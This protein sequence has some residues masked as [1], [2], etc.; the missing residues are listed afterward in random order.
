[1]PGHS[2]WSRYSYAWVTL[3]FFLV[4]LLLHWYFGW[5]SFVS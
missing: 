2:I 3:G 1:M 5:Q 4:S